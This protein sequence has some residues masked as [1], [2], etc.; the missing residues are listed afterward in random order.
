[1]AE[2]NQLA[3]FG[4]VSAFLVLV[5]FCSLGLTD[6]GHYKSKIVSGKYTTML[7]L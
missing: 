5:T 2:K 1:M 3:D 4:E 6:S 7:R